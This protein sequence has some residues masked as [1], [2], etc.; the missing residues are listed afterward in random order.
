MAIRDTNGEYALL[1]RMLPPPPP[2]PLEEVLGL[3]GELK[4]R[5]GEL[6]GE[7][8]MGIH[9]GRF[10]GFGLCSGSNSM[11]RLSVAQAMVVAYK[12]KREKE[13]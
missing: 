8:H 2:Q 13:R 11:G 6:D 10:V 12:T 3:G 5:G 7:I 9:R 4:F 1:R